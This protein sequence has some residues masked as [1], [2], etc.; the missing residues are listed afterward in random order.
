MNTLHKGSVVGALALAV[1]A[2][3]AQKGAQAPQPVPDPAS[4]AR[5]KPLPR[6]LE[7]GSDQCIPCKQM[8]PILADLRNE[9][10]G[11]LQ[12]DFIDVAKDREAG[13]R[14]KVEMIPTQIFFDA[15]GNELYRHVGFFGKKEIEA[16]IAELGIRL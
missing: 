5:S 2:V 10:D 16:K 1:L 11:K 14:Y 8:Q 15:E 3:I 4:T 6:L 7:V 9:H 12:V 13:E